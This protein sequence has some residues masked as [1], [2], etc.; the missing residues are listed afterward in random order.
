MLSIDTGDALEE[1]LAETPSEPRSAVACVAEAPRLQR[2]I[3]DS[4]A[5]G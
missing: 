1:P 5:W 4:I 2:P 3:D